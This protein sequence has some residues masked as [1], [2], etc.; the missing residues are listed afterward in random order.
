MHIRGI[1]ILLI[2]IIII[3]LL[4]YLVGEL[5]VMCLSD[6]KITS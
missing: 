3:L 2:N 1:I 5:F 6:K 4:L